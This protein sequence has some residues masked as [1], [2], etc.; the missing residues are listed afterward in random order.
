MLYLLLEREEATT[1][2]RLIG[3]LPGDPPRLNLVDYAS[4]RDGVKRH[5]TRQVPVPNENLFARL[6]REV[7][8][9]DYIR[10]TVVSEYRETGSIAYLSDFQKA[11][12]PFISAARNG[13]GSHAH[14][15]ITEVAVHPKRATNTKMKH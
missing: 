13:N 6:G 10:A 8:V 2:S 3:I 9:G 5:M 1:T 11:D 4:G 14:S 12:G 7:N 15:A